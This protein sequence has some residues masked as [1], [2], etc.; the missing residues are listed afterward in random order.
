MFPDDDGPTWQPGLKPAADLGP[1]PYT[2]HALWWELA[3]GAVWMSG[4]LIPGADY[5]P[6]VLEEGDFGSA[7]LGPAAAGL[8]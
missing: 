4:W 3:S 5:D 2:R 7:T 6:S 8:S 1:L